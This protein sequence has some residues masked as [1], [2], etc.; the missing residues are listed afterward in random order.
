MKEKTGNRMECAK[1]TV[2]EAIA[3]ERSEEKT[4]AIIGVE[5][6][7]SCAANYMYTHTGMK[8]RK[9]LF[10]SHLCAEMEKNG[11]VYSVIG[12]NRRF[13]KKAIKDLTKP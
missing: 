11:L 12:I 9:G 1:K 3:L 4:I 10:L 7:P 8:K 6:S 13:P 5:H 2:D